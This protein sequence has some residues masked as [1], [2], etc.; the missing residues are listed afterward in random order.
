MIPATAKRVEQHT[1]PHLNHRNEQRLEERV[2]Y[3]Q[4]QSPARISDRL[5]ELD[6]EWDVERT[7]QTNFA[8][9]SIVGALLTGAA[10]RHWA[11]LALGVPAFMVQ[12][13]IQ[14]WCPPLPVLRRLGIRTTREISDERFALKSL[15]GDFDQSEG[16]Q[17]VEALLEAVRK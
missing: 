3:Y 9:L 15:R 5:K 8:T 4:Q 13:A 10:N 7:L 16:F 6:Q 17:T 12:H 14:G 2:A 11:V 1:S